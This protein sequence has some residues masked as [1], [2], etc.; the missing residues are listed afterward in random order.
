MRVIIAKDQQQLKGKHRKLPLP[1]A[2]TTSYGVQLDGFSNGGAYN[3]QGPYKWNKKTT[4][5]CGSK[6]VFLILVLYVKVI[7][8][9]IQET[10]IRFISLELKKFCTVLLRTILL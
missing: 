2:Y 5:Q 3:I 1:W 9:V 10:K 4:P 7:E 6:N 8:I